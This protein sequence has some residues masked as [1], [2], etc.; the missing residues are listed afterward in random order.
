M[1]RELTHKPEIFEHLHNDHFFYQLYDE[2]GVYGYAALDFTYLPDCVLH[3]EVTRFNGGV[4]VNMTDSDWSEAKVI[5]RRFGANRV[6]VN[7]ASDHKDRLWSKFVRKFGFS[8]PV[9]YITA[10]QEI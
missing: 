7:H 10:Y 3:L 8:E 5:M 9:K 1:I 6:V 4:F 2:C